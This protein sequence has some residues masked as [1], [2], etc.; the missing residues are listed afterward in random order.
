MKLNK[1]LKS[2]RAVWMKK[3]R[4]LLMCARHGRNLTGERA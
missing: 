1:Q 3:S 4:P 2:I